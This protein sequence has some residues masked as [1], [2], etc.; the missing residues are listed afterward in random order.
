MFRG[1]GEMNAPIRDV[2]LDDIAFLDQSDDATSRSF[3]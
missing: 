1:D 3:G 2:D